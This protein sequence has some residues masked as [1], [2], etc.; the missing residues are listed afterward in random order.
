MQ[1]H[2]CKF[3]K[4]RKSHLR[5]C[6]SCNVPYCMK[7]KCTNLHSRAHV[8]DTNMPSYLR[9]ELPAVVEI[10]AAAKYVEMRGESGEPVVCVYGDL[11]TGC[12]VTVNANSIGKPRRGEGTVKCNINI[13]VPKRELAAADAP[14]DPRL[15]NYCSIYMLTTMLDMQRNLKS[16]V[17]YMQLVA[18]YTDAM[19]VI[20]EPSILHRNGFTLVAEFPEVYFSNEIM[21]FCT[22][23]MMHHERFDAAV[24]MA[25]MGPKCAACRKSSPGMKRCGGCRS[26]RYCSPACL[27]RDRKAHLPICTRRAS[28]VCGCDKEATVGCES[29]GRKVFCDSCEGSQEARV[30]HLC[31]CVC[32]FCRTEGAENQ[33]CHECR[34]VFCSNIACVV[35]HSTLHE[36]AFCNTGDAATLVVGFEGLVDVRKVRFRSAVPVVLTE[37][38]EVSVE[39]AEFT[40]RDLRKCNIFFRVPLRPISDG[41]VDPALDAFTDAQVVQRMLFIQA[42]LKVPLTYLQVLATYGDVV[43]L[44]CAQTRF[45]EKGI[46]IAKAV[47]ATYTADVM[48]FATALMAKARPEKACERTMACNICR[49]RVYCEDC[50]DDPKAIAHHVMRCVCRFCRARGSNRLHCRK[51]GY[52]RCGAM[53]CVA[54]HHTLHNAAHGDTGTDAELRFEVDG[55]VDLSVVRLDRAAAT[56]VLYSTP[57]M[58]MPFRVVLDVA[59][60]KHGTGKQTCKM[61]F[62]VPVR[63]LYDVL[64]DVSFGPFVREEMLGIM[65]DIQAKL[66]S[67]TPYLHVL[68]TYPDVINNITLQPQFRGKGFGVS[69]NCALDAM[70]FAALVMH[71]YAEVEVSFAGLDVDSVN[72]R[73]CAVCGQESKKSCSRCRQVRYCSRECQEEAWPSHRLD[74]LE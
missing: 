37:P 60:V 22:Y 50:A 51:C 36:I 14:V 24:P 26:V 45:E 46:F 68:A 28:P 35:L 48:K 7:P 70:Q 3:C 2:A 38:V 8:T 6:G 12:V 18:T 1:F 16:P 41:L 10:A 59:S 47:G 40:D 21:E 27:K 55:I 62:H 13:T 52:G 56:M 5:V 39:R 4:D 71:R 31:D 69:D 43:H 74:C 17:S 19:L 20:T 66:R 65:A 29:C 34:Q 9:V 58:T 32:Q 11:R 49:E 64:P 53:A 72:P 30:E 25:A 23:A 63:E 61:A 54:L 15:K 44:I 57:P 67:P 73:V 42:Q 33:Y